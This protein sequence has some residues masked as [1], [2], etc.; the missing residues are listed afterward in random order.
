MIYFFI[1][2]FLLIGGYAVMSRMAAK[3]FGA[4]DN[5]ATPVI[6]LADG[7][8]FVEMP[9]W[10]IFFVQ[11]LN[12]AGLGPIYG[13]ISGALFG[14][15]AF[16]W[17]VFGALFIGGMHDYFAAMIS[18]RDDG[19]TFAQ[20]TGKYL[21]K[22][23]LI[24]MRIFTLILLVL[25]ATVFIKGPAHILSLRLENHSLLS[26]SSFWSTIIFGYVMT[27]TLFPIDKITGRITPILG[28]AFILMPIA[29]LVILIIQNKVAYLPPFSLTNVH[30]NPV[31]RI[32]PMLFI[33]IACGA[34]SG[35]HATQSPLMARCIKKESDGRQIFYGAMIAES[36]VAL[37][38]AAAAMTFT[39]S[40]EGFS[41]IMEANGSN[42]A[43]VVMAISESWLGQIGILLAI[44]SVVIAP[45]TSA[46]TALRSARFTL[47]EVFKLPQQHLKFRLI[48]ATPLFVMTFI[49]L[50]IDFDK[51]W[52]YFAFFNQLLATMTLWTIACYF[53]QRYNVIAWW[54]VIAA[55]FMTS[56]VMSYI[57]Y[58]PEG[59]HQ[60]IQMSVILGFMIAFMTTLLFLFYPFQ[61]NVVS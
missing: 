55:I 42:P 53:K 46:D 31:I 33:T 10:R 50:N 22:T 47:A 15:V 5:I 60:S 34:V 14:P 54:P 4:D 37:I 2:L 28:I 29:L 7:V 56:V 3:T 52:R 43:V 12:I 24:I 8:D 27:A 49:M 32:W 38:W 26:S 25:L 41:S 40:I 20:S 1:S 59:L 44:L 61:K 13:A 58:A 11:F 19:A 9:K 23:M 6:R 51:I 39:G 57:L 16:V 18:L 17:I 21:G 36:S 48:L 45:V 30:F 35:F